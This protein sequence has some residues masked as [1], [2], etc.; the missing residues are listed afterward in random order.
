[1]GSIVSSRKECTHEKN[2]EEL[3]NEVVHDEETA[4]DSE[5]EDTTTSPTSSVLHDEENFEENPGKMQSIVNEKATPEPLCYCSFSEGV[6]NCPGC[7]CSHWRV[8]E[9]AASSAMRKECWRRWNPIAVMSMAAVVIGTLASAF[10]MVLALRNAF[11]TDSYGFPHWA[12]LLVLLVMTVLTSACESRHYVWV[13]KGLSRA[14]PHYRPEDAY[15]IHLRPGQYTP[16]RYTQAGCVS[17]LYWTSTVCLYLFCMTRMVLSTPSWVSLWLSFIIVF[18]WIALNTLLHMVLG[19]QMTIA[20]YNK[21]VLASRR[22][23]ELR[24]QQLGLPQL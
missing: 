1:M 14:T 11:K 16:L 9:N 15:D 2:H 4:S 8:E 3:K 19:T 18:A 20:E 10:F 23:E 12:M 6:Q 7:G 5:S 17:I 24:R 22:L 13:H 21:E